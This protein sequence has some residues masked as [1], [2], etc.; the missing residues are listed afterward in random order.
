MLQSDRIIPFILKFNSQN[1]VSRF[2]SNI[3]I[4]QWAGLKSSVQTYKHRDSSGSTNRSDYPYAGMYDDPFNPTE[5]LAFGLTKEVY[6]S[7]VFNNI[8]TFNNNNLY[9]KYYKKFIEEI[10]DP[11]SKIVNAHFYLTPNDIAN[12]S[13]KKQYYFEG[14]YFRLNKIENYNPSNPLTKCEFLKIKEA[15]V[16]NFST[17]SSNGG[18]KEIGGKRTPTFSN[19]TGTSTNG[20]TGINTNTTSARL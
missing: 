14:Q 8:I 11:N 18:V 13:F 9:N 16:F 1:G 19:G 10:T 2:Q 4:L 5:D 3:R 15:T 20:N 7:N 12:L 6:W 17:Q